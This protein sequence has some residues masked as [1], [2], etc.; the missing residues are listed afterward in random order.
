M[1]PVEN[2]RKHWGIAAPVPLALA[3]MQLEITGSAMEGMDLE[4][5]QNWLKLRDD[6]PS[7]G[8]IPACF[9][10]LYILSVW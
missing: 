10:I 9:C 1:K 8:F 2:V 4:I 6:N 5:W 7:H 3:G